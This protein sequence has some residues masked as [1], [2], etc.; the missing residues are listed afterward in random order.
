VKLQ[1]AGSHEAAGRALRQHKELEVELEDALIQVMYRSY[2][3]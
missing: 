1:R 3:M 2:V